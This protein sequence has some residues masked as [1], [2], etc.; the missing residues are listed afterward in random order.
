M[1]VFKTDSEDDPGMLVQCRKVKF[2][3]TLCAG[4]LYWVAND[5]LQFQY[6][7]H[8]RAI[9]ENSIDVN[10]INT[11]KELDNTSSIKIIGKSFDITEL[12]EYKFKEVNNGGY[13]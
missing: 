1:K 9:N 4:K 7:M 13:Q 12:L 11:T 2:N 6:I 3:P 5:D 10:I 8:V